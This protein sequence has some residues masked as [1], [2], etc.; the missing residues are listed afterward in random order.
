MSFRRRRYRP[1]H[2]YVWRKPGRVGVDAIIGDIVDQ[3]Q[4][5]KRKLRYWVKQRIIIRADAR[6]VATDNDSP[7][8]PE[9][10]PVTGETE[11][12]PA[13]EDGTTEETC[14]LYTSPSPRDS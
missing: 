3:S 13:P 5:H 9:T 12:P 8:E 11:T 4:Y 7:P 2:I 6:E 14:L 10:T 1:S